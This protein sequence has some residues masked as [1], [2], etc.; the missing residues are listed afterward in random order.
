LW[1]PAKRHAY[2]KRQEKKAKRKSD[3]NEASQG[4]GQENEISSTNMTRIRS[5]SS[6]TNET[7][8]SPILV[9]IPNNRV[10]V[11]H[12]ERGVITTSER[13]RDPADNGDDELS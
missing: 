6:L 13:L 7:I 10:V 11:P 5:S 4:S 9:G 8:S 1:W 12:R 3:E 2:V